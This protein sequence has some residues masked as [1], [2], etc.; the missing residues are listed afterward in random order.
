LASALR[1]A[2]TPPARAIAA[3]AAPSPVA[4]RGYEPSARSIAA[5]QSKGGWNKFQALYKS[6]GIPKET[7]AAMYQQAKQS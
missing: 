5:A 1:A 6:R 7:L 3:E 2:L 4:P